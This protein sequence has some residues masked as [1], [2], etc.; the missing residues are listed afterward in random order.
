MSHVVPAI[1]PKFAVETEFSNHHPG[2]TSRSN[3]PAAHAQAIR[4]G[5]AMAAT[6]VD[7]WEEPALIT[8]VKAAFG[9]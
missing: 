4:A 9:N 6:I 3:L 2:F 5:Q 7:L 1:H 8:E